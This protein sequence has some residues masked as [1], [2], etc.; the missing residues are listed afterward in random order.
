[1]NR[2]VLAFV[3]PFGM[4]VSTMASVRPPA[5][6]GG[7]YP[8]DPAGLRLMVTEFLDAAPKPPSPPEAMIVPH[9][10]YIFSGR[11]AAR[12]FAGLIG[13]RPRR[14]ILLGPSHH[15]YFAGAALPE[16]GTTAFATP[17]GNVPLDQMAVRRL[18]H[19]SEFDGPSAAHTREHSIEVELP[20][21]Q[22]ATGGGVPIVPILVGPATT[23]TG[24]RK[25][26][27]RLAPLLGPGT[28]VI[29]SSDFT[30][31]GAV[32]NHVPFPKKGLIPRLLDLG[33][34]TAGR[35]AAIDPDGFWQQ[36]EVSDDDVC[37][38]QP[39]EVLLQLLKR[40]FNGIGKVIAV[41]TSAANNRNL[42]QVVTYAAVTFNGGWHAWHTGPTPPKLGRL[43][44]KE[45]RALLELARAAFRSHLGHGA[46][47]ARWFATHRVDGN[48]SAIAGTFV[49]LTRK[50]L[51]A[52]R[53][54]R[55]CMGSIVG[56]EP[57]ADAVIHAAVSAA[58]DPRFPPLK[59]GELG[60]LHIEIS[61]LSPLRRIPGPG[62]IRLGTD[63][64]V[65]KKGPYQA[66]Y[67]PQVARETGWSREELLSHLAVKAGLDADAWR[68]GA[69]FQVFTAQ[70]FGAPF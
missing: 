13:T 32:Y 1:M 48:L 25:I 8:A 61:V 34:A 11:T 39:I 38:A 63:G 21:L 29:A 30:H 50:G 46:E 22:V 65:L 44:G 18:R 3:I 59:L 28:V 6:A 69:T 70:V 55:C 37:G 36:V 20:F 7:F 45:K 26:A 12:A 5:V 68:R 56:R 66:V 23:E 41:T 58:H 27:R 2:A 42:D 47:L 4:A 49:T 64:V 53:N 31:Y 62:M 54:L 19:F 40:T 9:A 24:A 60:G 33:R 67:L 16:A 57:L 10:G 15:M 17:L 51:P 14:V 52:A 43:T 35:A